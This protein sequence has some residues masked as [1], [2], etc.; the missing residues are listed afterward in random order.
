MAGFNTSRVDR[1]IARNKLKKNEAIKA[2]WEA[3]SDYMI[4]K[5][6]KEISIRLLDRIESHCE[7]FKEYVLSSYALARDTADVEE[8][9]EE[10]QKKIASLQKKYGQVIHYAREW[11][12]FKDGSY[13]GKSCGILFCALNIETE[14]EQDFRYFKKIFRGCVAYCTMSY[15]MCSYEISEEAFEGLKHFFPEY[16]E[17]LKN[18]CVEGYEIYQK[19]ME[20]LEKSLT[21]AKAE[22]MK[23]RTTLS[24]V[25]LLNGER[26]KLVK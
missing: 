12:I 22:W 1:L 19:E 14:D 18:Q 9:I 24:F 15:N 10:L 17:R 6:R 21:S 8:K 5:D 2:Y 4:E 16:I 3:L 11:I 26:V 23:R 20:R 13:Q 7:G 25:V